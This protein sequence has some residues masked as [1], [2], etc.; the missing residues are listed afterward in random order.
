MSRHLY[1]TGLILI[2]LAL[3]GCIWGPSNYA[4]VKNISDERQDV[5][6]DSLIEN[7]RHYDIYYA[8]IDVR[9]PLGIVFDPKDNSTKLTG[10]QW[11]RVEDKKI[12]IEITQWLYIHTLFSPYLVELLAPD[13]QSLGYLY[14][15]WGPVVIKKKGDSIFYMFNLDDPNELGGEASF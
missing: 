5:T 1:L 2:C 3:S 14:Y 13:N 4:K 8:G 7:W 15:S 6:I 9:A 10:D 12:L 11:K